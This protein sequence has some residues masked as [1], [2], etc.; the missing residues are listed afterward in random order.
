[1]YIVLLNPNLFL[2][3]FKDEVMCHSVNS[4]DTQIKV[5]HM[6]YEPRLHC[7]IYSPVSANSTRC[8]PPCWLSEC[9]ARTREATH[10]KLWNCHTKPP[11][12]PPMPPTP[13][14][15]GG[16]D[17]RSMLEL[18]GIGCSITSCVLGVSYMIYRCAS[19]PYRQHGYRR[20]PQ[21]SHRGQHGG[22]RGDGE[23]G[24]GG[25]HRSEAEDESER[26]LSG[27]NC[28]RKQGTMFA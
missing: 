27:E 25:G 19:R 13:D 3:R 12:T 7:T 8:K 23:I 10:C 16:F 14:T 17:W 15:D 2:Q 6:W 20:Q 24:G 1:M 28:T 21:Y 4:S 9:M 22:V 18:V 26:L 11:P 5:C